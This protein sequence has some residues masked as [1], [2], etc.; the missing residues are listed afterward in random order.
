MALVLA[1]RVKE[2]TTTTGT[3]TVTLAGAVTGYQSFS[4]IGN[5]NT[6]YYVIA[7]QGTAEWEVGI[8]TYT[9]SGTTLSRTTILASSNAGSAVSFSAGTKDVFVTYPAGKSVNLDASSNL[10]LGTTS[11]VNTAHIGV[12]TA[13]VPDILIRAVGDNNSTSRIA[14]RGYSSDANS[15]SMRVTK[16]R[17]TAGSPQAPQSG[18]SLGKF[19]LAGYGTTSSSGYPQ[20]SFEGVATEAWGATA[21]GAKTVIKVTPNTTTTQATALTIDQDKTATFVGNV[22]APIVSASNGLH[23]NSATVS[24]SYSIPSGSNAMSV[25]PM[26]VAS[27]QTVTVASGQRW[28]VL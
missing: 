21:R 18:D 20:A 15:S 22:S 25:G 14:V 1:D 26:T 27:G 12:N 5:A 10:D 7:G 9:S 23:V 16:F 11:V 24:A 17:G 13:T 19:E 4:A 8:G 3:G 2:T 6:T 28:V